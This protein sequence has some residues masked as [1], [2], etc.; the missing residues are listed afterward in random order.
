MEKGNLAELEIGSFFKKVSIKR[1]QLIFKPNLP[2]E[3]SVDRVV[4][5]DIQNPK[6]LN[7]SSYETIFSKEVGFF[8]ANPL[9][10]EEPYLSMNQKIVKGQII[11]GTESM[12]L[13]K[14]IESP[15][16]GRVNKI[17]VEDNLPVEYGQPL[18]RI[19]K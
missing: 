5:P 2:L 14:E 15:Y 7:E 1:K 6:S 9:E 13:L 8:R 18:F 12:G 4:S 16:S 3:K 11:E 19:E 10:G 17:Y